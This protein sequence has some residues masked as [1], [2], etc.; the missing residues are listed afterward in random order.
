MY[1]RLCVHACVCLPIIFVHT[2]DMEY[3]RYDHARRVVYMV[4]T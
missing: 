4:I 2:L 3:V 1:P